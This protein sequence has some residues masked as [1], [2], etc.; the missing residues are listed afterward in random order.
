[1]TMWSTSRLAPAPALASTALVDQAAAVSTQNVGAG[2]VQDPNTSSAGSD[3]PRAP[4]PSDAGDV[5]RSL[6][7]R[8]TRA[9]TIN[10]FVWL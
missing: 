4:K 10:D 6:L 2:R 5:R 7:V 1:M 9:T 8:I 3:D